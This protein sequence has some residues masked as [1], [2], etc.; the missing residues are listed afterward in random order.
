MKIA[1]RQ[2]AP[3]DFEALYAIDQACYRRAIAYSRRELRN[4]LRFPGADCIVAEAGAQPGGFILTAHQD[5]WGYIV[6]IDVLKRYR[7]HGLGTLLLRESERKLAAG[8]VQEVSLETAIDN[9]SGIAFWKKHGY[10]T[11]EIR[12]G[13]YPGGVDAFSMSKAL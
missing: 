7:R 8:G 9:P 10:R 1:L 13:Y 11:R 6:T 12:K 3:E 4:Y 5:W 2:Y